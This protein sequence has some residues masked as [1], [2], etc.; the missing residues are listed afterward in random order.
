MS[1]TPK[2]LLSAIINVYDKES[3]TDDLDYDTPIFSLCHLFPGLSSPMNKTKEAEE[4]KNND[5]DDEG[6][7]EDEMVVDTGENKEKENKQ[8][9]E[10]GY[11]IKSYGNSHYWVPNGVIATTSQYYSKLS[12]S[13]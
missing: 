4:E 8:T 9:Y 3:N 5:D 12:E 13:H 11:R 2:L 1:L 7:G 6:E 10:Q